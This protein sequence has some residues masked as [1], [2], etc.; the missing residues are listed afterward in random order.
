MTNLKIVNTVENTFCGPAV[1]SSIAGISTDEAA[2][3]INQVRHVAPDTKVIGVFNHEL[4]EVFRGLGYKTEDMRDFYGQS[5][6][7]SMFSLNNAG[8]YLFYVPGHVIVIEIADDG[9]RYLVDNH[10]KK[11]LNLGVSSRLGQRVKWVT[12]ISK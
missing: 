7:S 9:K 5:I 8:I 10:T 6:Y 4:R 1:I 2:K 3:L 11:P 12:R